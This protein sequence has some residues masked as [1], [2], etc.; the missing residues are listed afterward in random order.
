MSGA[1]Q[2]AKLGTSIEPKLHPVKM[3]ANIVRPGDRPRH[4]VQTKAETATIV[5]AEG[6]CEPRRL[7]AET[8]G[9]LKL[10]S[11]VVTNVDGSNST[12]M[13][14]EYN[15][16]GKETSRHNYTWDASTGTWGD[17]TEEYSW[18]WSE[19]GLILSEWVKGYGQ[20]TRYDY[21]YNDQNLGVKKTTFTLDKDGNWVNSNMGVYDYDDAG[22]IIE[23]YVYLWDGQDWAN[24]VHNLASWDG[25]KRQTSYE[26]YN[27]DGSRWV[28][29]DKAEY[30]WF[31]GPIDPDWQEGTEKERMT[32]KYNYFWMGDSFEPYYIFINKIG[33]DGR[34]RGQ[35]ERYYNRSNG[36]WSGGDD[37]DGRLGYYRTWEGFFTLDEHGNQTYVETKACLPDS[38][39]WITLGISTFDWTYA[40]DGS[41]EGLNKVIQYEY[42]DNNNKTGEL[43][44]Q[45]VYYAY[46]ARNKKTW[47]LQQVANGESMDDLFEEKYIYDNNGNLTSSMVWDW[48]DG[49]RTPTSWSKTTYNENNELVET[50]SLNGGSGMTPLGAPMFRGKDVTDEDEQ[51]WTNS[52][53]WTYAYNNGVLV[54]KKGYM[55]RNDAWTTNS[56]QEVEYDWDYPSADAIFPNG[57]TDPYKINVLRDIYGDGNNG[58]LAMTRNYYYSELN[59]SAIKTA[60]SVGN[61]VKVYPSCVTD[62]LYVEA[63]GDVDVNIYGV[64]GM[65]VASTSE[66]VIPMTGMAAGLYIVDVN[67]YKVKILKK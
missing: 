29:S 34:L 38:S 5:P 58:W 47:V 50:V 27:W 61:N 30:V 24:S 28:G 65:K 18:T 55:W 49:K 39:Q 13:V 9:K 64:G 23:E 37:W 20:G 53:R 59:T 54:D 11:I 45:Q 31:D 12:K 41:R 36:K 51:G 57:W 67:G 17:P 25:K 35:S 1:A 26:G 3:S 46:N 21:E 43:L 42:D 44:N 10:D 40:E 66:K 33:D 6:P 62:N 63:D 7:P 8:A 56:G 48:V 22:N 52:S 19:G 4:I 16:E 2:V 60:P 32:Y 15:E 14:F